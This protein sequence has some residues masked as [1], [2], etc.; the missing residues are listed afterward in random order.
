MKKIFMKW[1]Y[2]AKNLCYNTL[3][4]PSQRISGSSSRFFIVKG[5]MRAHGNDRN[6][7][8]GLAIKIRRF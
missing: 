7:S 8:F 2:K 4:R 5:L 3:R 6:V 1:L